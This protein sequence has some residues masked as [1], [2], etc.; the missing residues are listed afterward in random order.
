MKTTEEKVNGMKSW[1]YL[2]ERQQ[3]EKESERKKSSVFSLRRHTNAKSNKEVSQ[4]PIDQTVSQTNDGQK[5]VVQQIISSNKIN[6]KYL[7]LR[8]GQADDE[9]EE[10]DKNQNKM[11]EEM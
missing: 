6:E 8:N 4:R 2:A 9:E 3:I 7:A 5:F 10:E 1:F 11:K